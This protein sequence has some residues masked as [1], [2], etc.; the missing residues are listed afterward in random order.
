MPQPPL[1]SRMCNRPGLLPKTLKILNVPIHL[2]YHFSVRA[3]RQGTL[4]LKVGILTNLQVQYLGT[5]SN[6]SLS[7]IQS[8]NI[9]ML[10]KCDISSGGHTAVTVVGDRNFTNT[11]R[12]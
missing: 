11:L 12:D 9:K 8:S 2:S 5:N 7:P 10:F 4:Q 6:I 1:H 3:H